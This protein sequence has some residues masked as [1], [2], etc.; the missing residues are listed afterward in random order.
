MKK[1]EPA[2]K[3]LQRRQELI[4]YIQVYRGKYQNSPTLKEMAEH[5]YGDESWAGN[6]LVMLVRPLIEEKWLYRTRGDKG[7]IMVTQPQ[8]REFYYRE[9]EKV[10]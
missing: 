6:V 1:N 7:A 9:G 5:I 10:T 3:T 4:D 2:T 8:P